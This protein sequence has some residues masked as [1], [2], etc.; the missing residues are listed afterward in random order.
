MQ[1]TRMHKRVCED[2]ETKSSEEYLNLYIQSSTLLLTDIFENFQKRCLKIYDLDPA[3]FFSAFYL[4]W[5]AALKKTK[6]KLDLNGRKL[7]VEKGIRGQIC[8]CIY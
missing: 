4:A 8:H 5:Q 1:I 7:M 3:C 2:F 6:V